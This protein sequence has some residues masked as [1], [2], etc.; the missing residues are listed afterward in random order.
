MC[1]V[2][3]VIGIGLLQPMVSLHWGLPMKQYLPDETRIP[4]IQTLGYLRGGILL[5]ARRREIWTARF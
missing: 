1:P 4:R 3:A 2:L 5:A